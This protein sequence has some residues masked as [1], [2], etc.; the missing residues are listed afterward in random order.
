MAWKIDQKL[1]KKIMGV[2][3]QPKDDH[4][5]STL[6]SNENVRQETNENFE[7]S[8]VQRNLLS[9]SDHKLST[10]I[11]GLTWGQKFPKD[12]N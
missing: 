10:K 2:C 9:S 3:V 4:S 5:F 8:F 11:N 1:I 6:N 7:S 12:R